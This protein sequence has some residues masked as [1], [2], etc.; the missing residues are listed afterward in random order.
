MSLSCI[1]FSWL[2]VRRW[3]CLVP[4]TLLT[5]G[6]AYPA[7]GSI[8]ANLTWIPSSDP[9]VAGYNVYYGSASGQLTN[10]A[11][12][13]AVTNAVVP[14]LIENTIYFFA[15]KSY[16]SAGQ[17]SD[18][19]N[20]AAFTGVNATPE[21]M[22]QLRTLPKNFTSD[23]LVFSLDATAPPGATINPTNGI[24]YW[25][26]GHAYASTTNYINVMVTDTANP[27][28]NI[29]ETV[30]VS[31]S[32]YLEFQVGNIAVSAGQSA[33]LPLVVAASDSVSNLQI[34]LN[35]PTS[36]L[37]N[38]TLT[39]FAPI[40]AGS[41]QSQNGQVIIQ[42]QTAADQ[43]LQGTNLVGQVNFDTAGG[44]ASTIAYSI[45]APSA[46]GNTAQG[47]S[48]ANVVPQPGEVVVVGNQPMLRPQ[49][50]AVG[51]R[52]MTLFAN[53][54]SYQLL[55]TT[56]LIAPVTWTPLTSYQ[57]TNASQSVSLDPTIPAIYYRLQAL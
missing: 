7:F 5:A 44:Q 1:G 8:S 54:G 33:S 15:A 26:P 53:P 10:L 35:W 17:E 56:S 55:Y 34:T 3:V 25:T 42:L 37:L 22:V 40:V 13:G 38:P 27:A 46:S 45:P 49:A 2:A 41:I 36:Q 57:Q 48:Y 14:N 16:N 21:G 19:S 29:S 31:V 12:V 28:L 51:E 30:M 47:A 52:T 18:F 11:S 24:F 32:D 43:P 4:T 9:N 39:F 50:T 6:A 23:P 20:E